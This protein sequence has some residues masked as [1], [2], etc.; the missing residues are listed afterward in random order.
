MPG[1]DLHPTNDCVHCCSFLLTALNSACHEKIADA[2]AGCRRLDSL[3]LGVGV[4]RTGAALEQHLDDTA[5]LILPYVRPGIAATGVLHRERPWRGR[6][7]RNALFISVALYPA[8]T[9]CGAAR[10]VQY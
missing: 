1:L 3:A 5:L 6:S 2:V 9:G 10:G 4:A 7:L 8:G